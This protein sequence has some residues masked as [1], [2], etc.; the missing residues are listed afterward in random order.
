MQTLKQQVSKLYFLGGLKV[1]ILGVHYW[2]LFQVG[3]NSKTHLDGN[4]TW[5][6][7]Y[8]SSSVCQSSARLNVYS[9]NPHRALL[10]HPM[11][12]DWSNNI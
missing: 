9:I 11:D 12:Y 2:F 8:C 5:W 10:W 3:W 1:L 4:C 6:A 7:A